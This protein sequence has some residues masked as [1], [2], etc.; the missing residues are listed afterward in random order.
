[1]EITLV[2]K[3]PGQ[4]P[5]NAIYSILWFRWTEEGLILGKLCPIV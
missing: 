3:F 4:I 2:L 5:L 1:M